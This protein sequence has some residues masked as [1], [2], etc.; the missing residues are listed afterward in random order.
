MSKQ[1]L[2]AA[3]L[4]KKLRCT[5]KEIRFLIKKRS[6]FFGKYFIFSYWPQYPNN[7]YNQFSCHVAIKV[8]K[9]S[10]IRNTIKRAIF[11]RAQYLQQSHPLR[12][13][14]KIYCHLT[15]QWIAHFFDLTHQKLI[16]SDKKKTILEAV[17]QTFGQDWSFFI[18]KGHIPPH[19]STQV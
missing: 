6:A 10:V 12:G 18:R 14:F 17:S 19:P 8:H 11:D 13:Y 4:A 15:K 9:S 1:I 7:E 3:M 5:T 16:A 2:L